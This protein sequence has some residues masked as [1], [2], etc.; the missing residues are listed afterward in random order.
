MSLTIDGGIL[1]GGLA[2]R[3]GGQ[4]KGL[5]MYL[6]E[7]MAHYVNNALS[8]YV[9]N[10]I[11][12]CNRNDDAYRKISPFTCSDSIGGFQGPLA[13]ILGIMESSDADLFLISPCDTPL[14][15]KGF[16]KI[17]LEQVNKLL[18]R[19]PDHPILIAAKDS[20][21]NHPLHL[22][23]SKDYKSSLENTIKAGHKKVMKWMFDHNAEWL[24]FESQSNFVNF[25]TIEELDI[26]NKK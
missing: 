2:T 19:N 26:A 5:Q 15:G 22:C 10:V 9:R 25:N 7:P 20:S 3:M 23:I 21:H 8:P 1:A 11:I 17:M 24:N 4:D 13:G 6:D 12:N 18:E 14:I 16:A